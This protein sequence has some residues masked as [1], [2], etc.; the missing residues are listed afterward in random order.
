MIMKKR[1]LIVH[2]LVTYLCVLLPVMLA[3]TLVT[4]KFLVAAETEKIVELQQQAD[5]IAKLIDSHFREKE[6]AGIIMFTNSE[7]N[8]SKVF[9]NKETF[10]N[11]L[12]LMK[13]MQ[14]VNEA[15]RICIYYGDGQ[16]Y[17][18][19]GKDGLNTFFRIKNIA[20][21]IRA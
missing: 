6:D 21:I 10:R 3:S 20:V 18:S 7:M 2:F 11:A 16:I 13:S 1:K 5:E 17:S 15:E 19:A 4:E 14:A 8:D 9:Q 12:H